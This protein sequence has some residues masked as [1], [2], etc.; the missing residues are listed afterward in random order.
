[1]RHPML[2][3]DPGCWNSRLGAPRSV[4]TAPSP[5]DPDDRSVS[6][7]ISLADRGGNYKEVEEKGYESGA[8][9]LWGWV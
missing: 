9:D 4:S 5:R 3:L 7:M 1:M 2:Y 8:E 6:S